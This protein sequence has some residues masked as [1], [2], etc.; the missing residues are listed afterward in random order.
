MTEDMVNQPPH[1]KGHPSGVECIDIV[2][3][4]P[5]NIG[6]AMKY[7]WRCDSKHDDP[8]EDLRKAAWY[9]N[10]EIYRRRTIKHRARP[11]HDPTESVDMQDV[12]GE[13]RASKGN[14]IDVAP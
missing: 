9:I 7:L 14:G 12:R 1:Y 13:A 3:H 6:A 10:R 11:V 8:E 5:Y 2:E 4:L